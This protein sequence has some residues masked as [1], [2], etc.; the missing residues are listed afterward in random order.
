MP[1]YIQPPELTEEEELRYAVDMFQC[2]GFV[3]AHW[4]MTEQQLDQWVNI[5]CHNCGGKPFLNGK[6]VPQALKKK[7]TF[8][9]RCMGQFP[10]L[11]PYGNE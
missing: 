8:L 2:I 10:D 7:V 3:A 5:C 11:A 6:G 9:K 4:S 1:N